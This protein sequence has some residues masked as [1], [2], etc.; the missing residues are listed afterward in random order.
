MG[1]SDA[2]TPGLVAQGPARG[3]C[4]QAVVMAQAAGPSAVALCRRCAGRSWKA[5]REVFA[6][7]DRFEGI[8]H[9]G[10]PDR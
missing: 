10:Q 6:S 2:T 8:L 5:G 3:S 4:G 9:I 1:E 7:V